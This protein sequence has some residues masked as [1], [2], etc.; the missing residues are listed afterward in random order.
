M[1]VATAI[2]ISSHSFTVKYVFTAAVLLLLIGSGMTNV[3]NMAH[4]SAEIAVALASEI[5]VFQGSSESTPPIMDSA[6]VEGE[7]VRILQRRGKWSKIESESGIR[8]WVQ[9]EFLEKV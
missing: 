5:S 7:S 4:P 1:C 8:G 2:K 6:I 9:S 3:S